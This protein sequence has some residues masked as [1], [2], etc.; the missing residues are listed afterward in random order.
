MTKKT[1]LVATDLSAN[2]AFAAKWAS[3]YAKLADVE[4]TLGHVIEVSLPNWLRSAYQALEEKDK[5]AAL[6]E[7]IQQWYQTHTGERAAGVLLCGGSPDTELPKLADQVDASMIVLARSGK[8]GLSK[9]LAGSTAQMLVANAPR[10]VAI[11]HPD[12]T[13]LGSASRIAVATDLTES[14]EKAITAAALFTN[15]LGGHLDIIH[16]AKFSSSALEEGQT[17]EGLGQEELSAKT[18]AQMRAILSKHVGDLKQVDYQSH[19]VLAGPVDA[20]TQMAEQQRY[21]IVFVG[22]AASYNVVSNVF[23][24]VSVK[25]TQMLPCTVIVVPPHADI[26]T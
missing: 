11:V 2:S 6:E 4:V 21:D 25:L 19:V 16:A 5:R 20:V 13:E 1:I 22:N 15:T 26:P 8:S 7:R 18:D 14:A 9:L 17:P 24:R 23:G 3:H 10:P 12:H